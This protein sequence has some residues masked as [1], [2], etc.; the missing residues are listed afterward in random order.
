ME[1]IVGVNTMDDRDVED[2]RDHFSAFCPTFRDA[3]ELIGRRRTMD[4]LRAMLSGET[5][6][7]DITSVV[8]L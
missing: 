7:S 4:I 3:I 2:R 1:I 5:P 8:P 6:F